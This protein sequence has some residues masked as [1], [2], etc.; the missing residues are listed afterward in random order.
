MMIYGSTLDESHA[1]SSFGLPWC[2]LIGPATIISLGTMHRK[3]FRMRPLWK[4]RLP[5]E[6]SVGQEDRTSLSPILVSVSNSR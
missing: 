2:V 4:S 3:P 6:R 1:P 5:E